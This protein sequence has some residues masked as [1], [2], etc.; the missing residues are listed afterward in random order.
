MSSGNK[1]HYEF[2]GCQEPRVK[3]EN[4]DGKLYLQLPEIVATE[5]EVQEGDW[6]TYSVG[7]ALITLWKKTNL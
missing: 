3:V 1:E 4:I 5:L 2:V 7:D 6:V